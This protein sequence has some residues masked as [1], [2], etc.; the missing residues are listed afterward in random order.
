MGMRDACG[1]I[2]SSQPA[3]SQSMKSPKK[4]AALAAALAEACRDMPRDARTVIS[5]SPKKLAAFAS[6]LTSAAQVHDVDGNICGTSPLPVRSPKSPKKRAA[7][8][9]ALA[10]CPS[11]VL[12]RDTHGN[13][14]GTSP[15][16]VRSPKASVK[17][18]TTFLAT[19]PCAIEAW[20]GTG[21]SVWQ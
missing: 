21:C 19:T 4:G 3:P 17:K 8:A 2:Y 16:P 18:R 13:V 9:A 10:A 15:A 7:L 1:S 20:G 5:R 11:A 6:A 14:F 12:M